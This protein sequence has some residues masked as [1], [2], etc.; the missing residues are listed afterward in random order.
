MKPLS[1]ALQSHLDGELTTLAYLVKIT[2]ADGVVKGFTTHDRDIA[3][4][5]VTYQADGALTPSALQSSSGLNT[6]NARK[7]QVHASVCNAG[8]GQ[9]GTTAKEH[10]H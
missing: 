2:R 6:D 8:G 10:R 4:G 5:G 9:T 1:P 7:P 3:L